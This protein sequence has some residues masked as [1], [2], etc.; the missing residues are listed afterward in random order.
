MSNVALHKFSLTLPAQIQ[1][2]IVCETA[3]NN[4][5]SQ[6]NGA[7]AWTIS[8]IVPAGASPC[9]KARLQ[10]EVIPF[11]LWAA[12]DI[13]N[14]RKPSETLVCFLIKR[15]HLALARL[16]VDFWAFFALLRLPI[17]CNKGLLCLVWMDARSLLPVCFG[18]LFVRRARLDADKG[19]ECCVR[20][21]A[22]LQ[23]VLE[24]EELVICV[25]SANV[26]CERIIS[27][28]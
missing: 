26:P 19:V 14:C 13:S 8:S 23:L 2:P 4:E 25:W 1:G 3:Q 17:I 5:Q 21:F 9:R 27:R 15:I 16:L 20:S 28:V 7:S 11:S 12:Q 24:L 6:D 22:L 10:E 18:D